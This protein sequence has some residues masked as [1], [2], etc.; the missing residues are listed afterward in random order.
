MPPY[1]VEAGCKFSCLFVS[2]M[3]KATEHQLMLTEHYVSVGSTS[4]STQ[5][6]LRLIRVIFM[7]RCS[8]LQ[9]V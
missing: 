8:M 4:V 1:H 5:L 7:W 2:S 9:R 3:T 6:D